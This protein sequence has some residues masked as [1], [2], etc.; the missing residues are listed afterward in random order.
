MNLLSG[1]VLV[2][3]ATGGI[4]QAIARALSPRVA[5]LILT[6]RRG[7]VLEALAAELGARGTVCD[8][9]RRDELERLMRFCVERQL[10]PAID[11]TLA[12]AD[13]REG[14]AANASFCLTRPAALSLRASS[15]ARSKS[16]S[17]CSA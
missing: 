13:A 12:L 10:R 9:S 15:I 14:F 8:L 4:G 6:G 7:H 5:D 2:T 1:T 3:G 17:A 11:T 16:A